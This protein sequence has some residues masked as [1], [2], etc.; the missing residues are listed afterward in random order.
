MSIHF[1]YDISLPNYIA[2]IKC[3]NKSNNK[4]SDKIHYIGFESE[5]DAPIVIQNSFAPCTFN[6]NAVK[7]KDFKHI[8]YNY[9][10]SIWQPPKKS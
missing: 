5:E 1:C 8:I 9:Q 3:E 6:A 10:F 2:E 4:E 7:M